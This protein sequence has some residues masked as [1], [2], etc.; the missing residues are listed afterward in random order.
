MMKQWVMRHWGMH[1]RVLLLVGLGFC[2]APQPAA[3]QTTNSDAELV[4]LDANGFIRVFDPTTAANSANV[5]WVSPVGGWVDI[6]VADFNGDGD[7]EIAAVK[8]TT[9]S[10]LLTIYDPVIVTGAV[11]PNQL[12]NG[13]PWR[14]LAEMSLPGV[15]YLL[16]AGELDPNVAG[17]EILYAS[18]LNNEDA[19]EA[20]DET[21]LT[22]LHASA[23]GG[24]AWAALAQ[25]TTGQLPSQITVG[26]LDGVAPDEVVLTHKSG[27]L[28][29]YRITAPTFTRMLNRES[30]S[31]E[32][33]ATAIARFFSIGLPGLIT[34]RSSSP[35]FPSFVVFVYDEGD[36]GPFRDAHSEFFLPG[37]ERFFVGDIT[38]NGDEEAFFLRTVPSNV[39][40]IPR[41]VMRNRGADNPPAF[42]EALD[43]DNGYQG[44]AAGDVDGDGRAEIIVMRNN[45]I[46][47]YTQPEINKNSTETT[48]AVT[49]NSR[50][51]V[52]G[53]LDRNGYL[54]TPTF[55]LTPAKVEGD[56]ASGE[57]SAP[58]SLTL[59][60]TGFGGA[61][62]FTLHSDGQPTWLR[63]STNTG[64]TP[65]TFTVALDARLL[66]AGVYSTTIRISSSN[67]QVNN[68]PLALPIKLTVRAGLAPRAFDVILTPTNCTADAPDLVVDLPIDGPAGMTFVARILAATATDA[69]GDA[70]TEA[71]VA[72]T[73]LDW[74][75]AVPW[76]AAQSPNTAP[77]TMQLTFRPQLVTSG[78]VSAILQLTAADSRGAQTRRIALGLLCTQ[79]KL[80]LPVVAR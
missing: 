71:L 73:S 11:V 10:G 65:A 76:V 7:S 53:N 15:P 56:L 29:V 19:D 47:I 58:G 77:T 14:I 52:A 78:F 79:T 51:L 46:R 4:Y 49:T 80:Y 27:T 32:W 63:L 67:T 38:G 75:S 40:T 55:S 60:N 16:G 31:Q 66:P 23:P 64:Q 42:E 12:F 35:G 43:T 44:G 57:Q 2:L 54:R 22:I 62:P 24:A 68:A 6:A 70:A 37:P 9:G 21:A 72:P 69:S 8:G 28:E 50:T 39:T 3:A 17:A 33:K 1:L 36:S 59:T 34:G 5:Q 74:P 45:K 25:Q 18:L 13:V 41:L 30:K 26:N 61:L 48:P 20:N